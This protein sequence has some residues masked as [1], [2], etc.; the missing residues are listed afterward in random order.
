[1]PYV[2]PFLSPEELA[3][4][5]RDNA[6]SGAGSVVP[7]LVDNLAGPVFM[8][9][10]TIIQQAQKQWEEQE[11]QTYLTR[12][13]VRAEMLAELGRHPDDAEYYSTVVLKTPAYIQEAAARLERYKKEGIDNLA[14]R[15]TTNVQ[16]DVETRRPEIISAVRS[17]AEIN[18]GSVQPTPT[19]KI[20]MVYGG[21]GQLAQFSAG[22]PENVE[23]TPGE[24][25][26]AFPKHYQPRYGLTELQSRARLAPNLPKD[27]TA[28]TTLAW[29]THRLP[30]NFG[31]EQ[32][33]EANLA[34]MVQEMS[35]DQR[36]AKLD[37]IRTE[38][39]RLG[40]KVDEQRAAVF[41]GV[42][43]KTPVFS[44]QAPLVGVNP[45]EALRRPA[46]GLSGAMG[47]A[48]RVLFDK[49][50]EEGTQPPAERPAPGSPTESLIELPKE[51]AGINI[52]QAIQDIKNDP[53]ILKEMGAAAIQGAT[54]AG[55]KGF[56]GSTMEA[57]FMA[58]H[59]RNIY[60]TAA[61]VVAELA[62]DKA[63]LNSEAFKARVLD[64]VKA[65]EEQDVMG[66]G[67]QNP[68]RGEMVQEFVFDPIW[69]VTPAKIMGAVGR[70]AKLIPGVE[71]L[72]LQTGAKLAELA[73]DVRYQGPMRSMIA[74]LR[75]QGKITSTE[76]NDMWQWLQFGDQRARGQ[77]LLRA[78]F[79]GEVNK[80]ELE[81]RIP[82]TQLGTTFGSEDKAVL[83][84]ALHGDQT[85]LNA[86]EGNEKL[87]KA[88]EASKGFVEKDRTLRDLVPEAHQTV[89]EAGEVQAMRVKE[90]A[91]GAGGYAHPEVLRLEPGVRQSLVKEIRE[92]G[93]NSV[94]E[95]IQALD[96]IQNPAHE[97]ATQLS[98][99]NLKFLRKLQGMGSKV[100][101]LGA[102]GGIR[103]KALA[104]SAHA[105][106]EGEGFLPDP[107]EQWR[108]ATQ[109]KQG[110]THAEQVAIQNKF[111]RTALETPKDVELMGLAS[112][113]QEAIISAAEMTEKTGIP[114]SYLGST[115][116]G[117]VAAEEF[118]RTTSKPG[119]TVAG[120]YPVVP[121]QVRD[122]ILKLYPEATPRSELEKAATAVNEYLLKPL[123][124]TWRLT[125]TAAIPAFL[126]T[127]AVG[128]TELS[129]LA[130]GF[131]AA[132]PGL[133]TGAAMTAVSALF[134]GSG[135]AAALKYSL[136]SGEVIT[137]GE[138]AMMMRRDG[139]IGLATSRFGEDLGH[140][141]GPL[142]AVAAGANTV[143]GAVG[144]KVANQLVEDY[145]H[146][147]V[148]LSRLQG[149]DIVSRRNAANAAAEL[150]GNYG[151]YS[152][153]ETKLGI[154]NLFG[155]YG[156]NRFYL[157]R[158]AK[159]MWEDPAR[160]TFFDKIKSWRDKENSPETPNS[161]IPGEALPGWQQINGVYTA[162]KAL[163]NPNATQDSFVVS[164]FQTP[165]QYFAQA[166]TGQQEWL[167]NQMGPLT[168]A[169]LAGM[170]G[171][172]MKTGQK[173]PESQDWLQKYGLTP[174][175]S[176]A[177][178]NRFMALIQRAY[179]AG[180]YRTAMSYADQL[181]LGN[182]AQFLSPALER[183]TGTR[184]PWQLGRQQYEIAPDYMTGRSKALELQQ[185]INTLNKSRTMSPD[186]SLPEEE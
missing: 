15:L 172:D 37:E 156:W 126:T 153:M 100:E 148:Y 158:V 121:T 23:L 81:H 131:K 176:G 99:T 166:L 123:T 86:L 40:Q 103:T 29:M 58:A 169:V 107:F 162:P 50:Q 110:T 28:Q 133:Q 20:K 56:T 92:A 115:K 51:I 155:F 69:L 175:P 76:A 139:V 74:D 9:A 167:T 180:K 181:Y 184:I 120:L 18:P 128:A 1:M 102:E 178:L 144:G 14:A 4:Q 138:A 60:Q 95:A 88:Y 160:L 134:H 21:E 173:V 82:L 143:V 94:D 145:Q 45:L 41:V 36:A 43:S 66:G 19:Q 11:N 171:Y 105:R 31:S 177:R 161:V 118:L 16:A 142:G 149:T 64:K 47:G 119:S 111:M 27:L 108:A 2:P 13:R 174:I 38:A 164:T 80:A 22:V 42:P 113:E 10:D 104:S 63:S 130:D 54:D 116:P 55:I 73:K 6:M 39:T 97:A 25:N 87:K 140:G 154:P 52:K 59:N 163:Q 79:V 117:Q 182:E 62:K 3:L 77:G 125:T 46:M 70:L 137:L 183:M 83:S 65:R 132:N 34:S 129:F 106:K 157:P 68:A 151:R 75:A 35:P 57:Q 48:A 135:P 109:G 147:T 33:F 168:Q 30:S 159:V 93:F 114:F 7:G 90:A 32:D 101:A 127:N 53:G 89:D 85:A 146:A 72:G 170:T 152:E 136:P 122:T 5:K 96:D 141:K 49:Q 98:S 165:S 150:T 112:T 44:A 24:L 91:V 179:L 8:P 67:L 186:L 17:G 71:K 124:S 185:T 78:D 61:E 26:Q 84:A 12:K